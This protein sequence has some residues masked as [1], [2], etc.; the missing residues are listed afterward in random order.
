VQYADY[1]LWQRGWLSGA[2][3]EAQ[4]RYWREQLRGAP[5]LLA[6]PTDRPRPPVQSYA[7]RMHAVRLDAALTKRLRALAQTHGATLYMVLLAGWSALL[8][9]LSGQGEVVIGSPVANR[10]RVELEGLIG[11]F[12]NTLALRTRVENLTKV[13]ALL[14]DIRE[15]T[16]AAHE[17]QDLPFDRVVDAV[18]PSRTLGHAPIFQ[19]LLVLDNTTDKP[20][21]A[22]PG[23]RVEALSIPHA[24]T[25]FD[26]SLSL[27]ET[28]DGL[29]GAIEYASDLFDEDTI[30][31]W[32]Q[33][34]E[35][36]LDGM[37]QSP[38]AT[39][40]SL[41]LLDE[42]ER[43]Q[44][45]QAS[46]GPSTEQSPRTLVE[47][48][49][50]QV[51]RTPDAVALRSG[52]AQ[53]SYAQLEAASN[54]VAHALIELGVVPDT[55]VGLCAERGIDLVV[56]LL[57]ILKAGGAYVPLDPGYPR[58]RVLQM[59]E[60]AAPI[61]VVSAGG[62]VA[63]L[64]VD[65]VAVLEVQDTAGSAQSHAPNVTLR[66]DHLAYVIYT[67]GSTGRPK[68]VAIEHRNTVNL[69]AWAHSAFAPEELARTV[70]STSV[71]FDLAVFELLVPLTQGGSVVLVEDLLRA[72]AQLEGA[73]LVNTVPSVLKAVLDAGGLPASVRAVNLAGE[74]LKRELVEQVFAQTQ[75]ARVVNLYGPTETTTYSTWV[76][77]PRS[78]GFVPGIGAPIAN[79]RAYVVDEHGELV[80]PGVVGE[81][82]LGGAG[83]ARGYL[84]RPELTAERFIDDP[85]AAGGRVYRTGDLVRRRSDGG[86]D[87]LGRN[88]FQVK[89]RGYRIELGEI[90]AALQA[91]PGV[92]DVVVVARGDAGSERTLVAYWQGDAIEASAL[93]GQMQSRLPEYMLPS[94]FV[95][96]DHW[97][98]TPNGKLDRAALPAPEGDAHARQ[99]YEAP[100]GE[101]EQA[102]SQVW[103]ELL[104]V[105]R[106]GR[107]DHFFA[108]GGHSL[109]VVRL[110]AMIERRLQHRLTMVELFTH[111][112]VAQLAA[113]IRDGDREVGR[114]IDSDRRGEQR[115]EALRR[116][117]GRRASAEHEIE[118]ED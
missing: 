58:E 56:G 5:E 14:A 109:L 112:T 49:E 103:T 111:T 44:L 38:E 99:A 71:N 100:E 11:F 69:L 50:S 42:D 115:R 82:W 53:L 106:V 18:Q 102:L 3:W 65:A 21:A 80:A 20:A 27:T 95:H 63:R 13:A 26:I 34:L 22:L 25:Q 86:L 94:A 51:A 88:D 83:V 78:A 117:R 60:D 67:S 97:P 47:L 91:C 29:S 118:L 48:F 93:R 114:L 110:Q 70:C 9:R 77:M 23:M 89:L 76:W 62:A 101:V 116:R 4:S 1:A 55:C 52:E 6:L 35:R 73:T 61:A 12:V 2:R 36:L 32:S 108:L 68:G 43:S 85:F 46:A 16:L 57:G 45:L 75:T 105:E 33:W 74:P 30:A 8:S 113:F 92:R 90:E 87:Y 84:H 7:G 79:T 19:T 10:P 64:G 107:H 40:S 66:P 37:A 41:A 54:R 15:T 72:G 31:R 28:Q 96:V 39:V 81:L 59:L 24:T 17:H 104:G 98:L